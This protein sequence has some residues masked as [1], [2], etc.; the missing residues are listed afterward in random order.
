MTD[1]LS[2]MAVRP[3]LW[4]SLHFFAGFRMLNTNLFLIYKTLPRLS[5]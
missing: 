1:F 3:G 4:K 5:I 2:L